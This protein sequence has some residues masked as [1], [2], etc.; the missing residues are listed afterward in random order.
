MVLFYQ[1]GTKRARIARSP[2]PVHGKLPLSAADV[3][4]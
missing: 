3:S 2:L 4:T 1:T